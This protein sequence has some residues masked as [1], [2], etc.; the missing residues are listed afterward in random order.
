MT[1]GTSTHM[2]RPWL[3][4]VLAAAI[5]IAFVVIGLQYWETGRAYS[6]KEACFAAR[7]ARDWQ[8]AE[9]LAK[10][11]SV[12]ETG[13][14]DP[15]IIAAEAAMQ[16]GNF[17]AA[18]VYLD[19]LPDD[20]P[21]TIP[22]LLQRVDLMFGQLSLP[23]EAVRTIDRIFALDPANCDARM[24]LT[25]YYAITLQR[26]KTAE[27]T[28][29]T[30]EAGCD[31]PETYVYL[32]GA[33]WLTLSNTE[34]VNSRWL[35]AN[36]GTERYA[37]AVIRGEIA[38]RGLEDSLN[39][40][41]AAQEGSTSDLAQSREAR[42]RELFEQYPEN[43]EALAYFLQ[44]AQTAGDV[45]EVT[46]LLAT[47]PEAALDDNRFWR[48]KAWVHGAR[49]ELEEADAAYLQARELFPFDAMAM[50]EQAV[51]Q[52][53]LGNDDEAARLADLADRGR[54]L[55]RTIL[56][57]PSVQATPSETLLEIADYIGDCGAEDIA[58]RLR[59]RVASVPP[60]IGVGPQP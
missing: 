3:R 9:R 15:L 16:Q 60:G 1:E 51:I 28:R 14:A 26:M 53:K 37:I 52:R 44:K 11:W 45:E 8:E 33:D 48:F 46:R 23:H 13:L 59:E 20:D 39:D 38:N 43:L 17:T 2:V 4:I 21:K 10:E 35:K 24:R 31:L 47:A 34:S 30:I 18:G 36:P 58:N 25:F 41:A 42:L 29:R 54:T 19:A 55:R 49:N 6:L 50:H 56:V 40:E 32:M 22:A 7:E 12:Y 27:I 57:Q 5:V